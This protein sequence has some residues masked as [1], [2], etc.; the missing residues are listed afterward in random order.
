MDKEPV[1]VYMPHGSRMRLGGL[2][3]TLQAP[4]PVKETGMVPPIKIDDKKVL[5]FLLRYPG[6]ARISAQEVYDKGHLPAHKIQAMGHDVKIPKVDDKGKP[7]KDEDGKPMTETLPADPQPDTR[8][9]PG[10]P[11]LRKMSMSELREVADDFTDASGK[12]DPIHL[13]A[14][15]TKDEMVECIE[16]AYIQRHK[17]IGKLASR[18]KGSLPTNPDPR[19]A[20]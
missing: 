2:G 17:E 15:A 1:S 6:T 5:A 19:K 3:V 20:K 9:P 12:K 18:S 10:S 13:P 7:V 14:K 11:D 4:A 8:M 16:D